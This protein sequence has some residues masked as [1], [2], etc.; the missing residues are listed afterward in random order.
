MNQA[1]LTR[2]CLFFAV[3]QYILDLATTFTDNP[4]AD[5]RRIKHIL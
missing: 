2:L 1:T 4:A 3:R 5:E